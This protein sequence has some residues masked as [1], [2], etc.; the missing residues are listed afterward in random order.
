MSL[1]AHARQAVAA[2]TYLGAERRSW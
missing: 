2:L 1:T